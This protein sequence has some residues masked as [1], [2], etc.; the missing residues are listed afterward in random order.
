MESMYKQCVGRQSV[1]SVNKQR[2]SNVS[3]TWAQVRGGAARVVENGRDSSVWGVL[4]AGGSVEAT[5]EVLYGGWRRL[6][7]A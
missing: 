3:C 4:A 1:G 2:Y 5:V 7:L 6:R